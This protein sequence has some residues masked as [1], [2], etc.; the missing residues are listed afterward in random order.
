MK[1]CWIRDWKK[2][3]KKLKEE[4]DKLV[5]FE[6]AYISGMQLEGWISAFSRLEKMGAC[7]YLYTRAMPDIRVFLPSNFDSSTTGVANDIKTLKY[8]LTE[9]PMIVSAQCKKIKIDIS[10]FPLTCIEL[11]WS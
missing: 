10:E 9:L 8:I 4:D 5:G 11:E 2:E 3:L 6:P 7:I 1:N